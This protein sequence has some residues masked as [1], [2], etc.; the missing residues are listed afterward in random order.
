MENKS[1][2]RNFWKYALSY[3][4]IFILFI[5][6]LYHFVNIPEHELNTE[7]VERSLTMSINII[8]NNLINYCGYLCAFILW[9]IFL[10]MDICFNAWSIVVSLKTVGIMETIRHLILH[11]IIEIPNSMMYTYLAYGAFVKFLK[12][13]DFG[14]KEYF[15]YIYDRK[16]A[17]CVCAIF[18]VIAGLV[19][20]LLS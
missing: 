14:L 5:L 18:V 6:F 4:L 10:F 9:P 17:Y 7:V 20:G 19:E 1:I 12:E 3:L 8:R 11:G 16:K 2:F 13:K 15:K